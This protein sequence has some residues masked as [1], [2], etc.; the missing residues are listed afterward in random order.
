MFISPHAAILA[1][2]IALSIA[3]TAMTWH[4]IPAIIARKTTDPEK[5]AAKIN[6]HRRFLAMLIVP[7]TIFSCLAAKMTAEL[8][9]PLPAAI[10]AG[11]LVADLA[12]GL[13]SM[14]RWAI[15]TLDPR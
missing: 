9:S 11:L 2:L 3:D 14:R 13:Y 10:V 4:A 6:S 1:A 5:V 8:A 15:A 7:Y 12:F